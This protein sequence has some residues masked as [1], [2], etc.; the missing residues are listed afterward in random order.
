MA[1][2]NAAP[3]DYRACRTEGQA[4]HGYPRRVAGVG[5]AVGPYRVEAVLGE[6]G[7]GQVFRAAHT[8]SGA[9]VALKLLKPD[10]ATDP[11]LIRRLLREA[12]AAGT[13]EHR[14]LVGVL[15]A[16]QADGQHYL[17]LELVPGV[18]VGQRIDAEGPLPLDDVVRI[19]AGVAAGLDALHGA[20]IV[21]RDIKPSNVLLDADDDDA[22]RLTD[23][24]LA[25]GHDYSALTLPGQMLGTIDYLAP[26]LIRGDEPTAGSDIYAFGCLVYAC[27]AGR[28]PFGG[29]SLLQIGV[30]HLDE[31]PPDPCA[32]RS[33]APEGFG[34][35]VCFAL[36]K[37]P[38]ERPATAT[39]Y[40]RLIA[41]GARGGSG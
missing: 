2:E 1:C 6:G 17:A 3:R 23:F 8:Q 18:T 25:K 14:H 11:S 29:R 33:D 36:R 32:Q 7:M 9:V 35:A 39:A 26:E 40:A 19:A 27:V 34:E 30:G 15:D 41:V 4:R 38:A 16:G 37:T 21:H 13:V 24:G 12:R 22:A 10:A 20:G 5:D 31:E 28:P